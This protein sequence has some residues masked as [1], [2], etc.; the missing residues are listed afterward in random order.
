MNSTQLWGTDYIILHWPNWG[1]G[2]FIGGVLSFT[3]LVSC[4]QFL[5]PVHRFCLTWAIAAFL[6]V[7]FVTAAHGQGFTN[8]IVASGMDTNYIVV[9][10]VEGEIAKDS[11]L[12]RFFMG[13]GLAFATWLS[14]LSFRLVMRALG[15]AHGAGGRGE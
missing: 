12:G 7:C 2:P 6:I 9:Y 11:P 14:A 15:G 5:K 3:I 1:V 13:F 4:W 10:G 8:N